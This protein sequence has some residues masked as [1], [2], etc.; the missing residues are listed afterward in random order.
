M[1]SLKTKLSS[2]DMHRTSLGTRPSSK[3]TSKSCTATSA[4][5]SQRHRHSQYLWHTLAVLIFCL[6]FTQAVFFTNS[7]EN[8]YPRLGRRSAASAL[9]I[10]EDFND[11]GKYSIREIAAAIKPRS[12]GDML[13]LRSSF[14]KF[15]SN[16]EYYQSYSF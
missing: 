11:D 10:I 13:F 14:R 8:D 15:D 6:D 5:L 7:K 16:S 2:W 1:A 9:Q 3:L 12:Y 4:R